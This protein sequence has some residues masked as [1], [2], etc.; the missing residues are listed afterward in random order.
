MTEYSAYIPL[1]RPGQHTMAQTHMSFDTETTAICLPTLPGPSLYMFW[2]NFTCLYTDYHMGFSSYERKYNPYFCSREA[3]VSFLCR[4]AEREIKQLV[5]SGLIY[6]PQ[7]AKAK[8]CSDSR[9]SLTL[10]G[11]L[12]GQQSHCFLPLLLILLTQR[13]FL[14]ET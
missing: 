8:S 11:R 4:E 5:P 12:H 6:M 13:R 1:L 10:S 3:T 14:H 7:L 2:F 9:P